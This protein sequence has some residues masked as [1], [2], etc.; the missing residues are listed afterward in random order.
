MQQQRCLLQQ[1]DCRSKSASVY[2]LQRRQLTRW[3]CGTVGTCAE[4]RARWRIA[5]R[6]ARLPIFASTAGVRGHGLR[7]AG[8]RVRLRRRCAV[9]GMLFALLV[10][11]R[12]CSG[13]QHGRQDTHQ[14]KCVHETYRHFG[15]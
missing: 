5:P 15:R 3:H 6:T 4:V 8:P 14:E 13:M 1:A 10:R 11:P 7:G 12:R 9:A 2:I